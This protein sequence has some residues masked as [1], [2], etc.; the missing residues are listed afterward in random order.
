MV[1]PIIGWTRRGD[2][3]HIPVHKRKSYVQED[4]CYL[5]SLT[6]VDRI[7]E[8]WKIPAENLSIEELKCR[9]EGPLEKCKKGPFGRK[10]LEKYGRLIH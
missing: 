2:N 6:T 1:T 4:G 7:H 5:V 3:Y 10:F 9:L 8:L